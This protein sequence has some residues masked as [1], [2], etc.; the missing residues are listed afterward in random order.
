MHYKP[1]GY[2]DVTAYLTV[3]GASEAIEFYTKAFGAKELYRLAMPDGIIAHAEFMIGD[4]KVMIADENKDWGNLSPKSLGGFSS[5][6]MIYVANV[7]SFAQNAIAHGA[8]LIGEIEDQFYGD[9]TARMLDP[10]GH[11]WVAATHI[12]EVSPEEMNTRFQ[13]MMGG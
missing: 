6:F 7:D 11:L 2:A 9:R 13:A 5:L 12:E 8:K 10:F 1:D 3:A 4:S